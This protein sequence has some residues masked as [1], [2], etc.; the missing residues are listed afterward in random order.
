[1]GVNILS[2]LPLKTTGGGEKYMNPS[3]MEKYNIVRFP[4]QILKMKHTMKLCKNR[5]HVASYLGLYKCVVSDQ[6]ELTVL[7]CLRVFED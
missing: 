4:H 3:V 7:L 2:L 5:N 6:H 1:M